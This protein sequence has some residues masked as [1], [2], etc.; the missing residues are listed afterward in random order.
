[1]IDLKDLRSLIKGSVNN[2]N[3]NRILVTNSDLNEL[4]D[5]LEAAQ[6]DQ[7]RYQWLRS[8]KFFIHP[9]HQFG[10]SHPVLGDFSFDIWSENPGSHNREGLDAAIDAAMEAT[11]GEEA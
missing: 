1:M 6:K 10:P 4:L 9:E 8:K 2:N 3:W 7:A 5:M 11:K